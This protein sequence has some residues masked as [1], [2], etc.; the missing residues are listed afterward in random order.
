VKFQVTSETKL[1]W[2]RVTGEARVKKRWNQD[3]LLHHLLEL[4]AAEEMGNRSVF[5]RR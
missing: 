4:Y 5:H 2:V 1:A 3:D